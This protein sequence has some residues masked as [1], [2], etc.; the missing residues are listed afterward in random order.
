MNGKTEKTGV[1]KWLNADLFSP[2]G[3]VLRA[4]GIA[5]L[6][7]ICELAG[8]RQFTTF[9]SGTPV[10]TS[11]GLS[12]SAVLGMLYIIFYLSF[13]LLVPI[14]LLGA[15]LLAGALKWL[16]RREVRTN[17]DGTPCQ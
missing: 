7:V 5:L 14:L 1:L 10:S 3:L 13:V 12:G 15:L 2:K 11:L 17:E 9:L 16:R 4:G 8:L 6:F